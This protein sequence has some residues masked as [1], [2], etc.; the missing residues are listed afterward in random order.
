MMLILS[1]EYTYAI[2]LWAVGIILLEMLVGREHVLPAHHTQEQVRSSMSV[3][4]KIAEI[5]VF[6][7][8]LRGFNRLLWCHVLLEWMK[9]NDSLQSISIFLIQ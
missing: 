4:S 9:L 1:I 8:F 7:W 3:I 6:V 5:V 2:D